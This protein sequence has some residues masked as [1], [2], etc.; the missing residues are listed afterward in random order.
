MVFGAATG[1][2]T[3][4]GGTT[5]LTHSGFESFQVSGSP[6]TDTLAGGDG[7]D[8]LDMG[9]GRGLASGGAGADTLSAD[10]SGEG[11]G[12]VFR[13]A[14]GTALAGGTQVLAHSGFESFHVRG[15]A[16]N[17][18]MAGG[19]GNDWLDLGM[20]SGLASGGA[21]TD[22]LGVDF[23]N[24]DS[25]VVF[26]AT[27]SAVTSRRRQYHHAFWFRGIPYSWLSAWRYPVRRRG[28]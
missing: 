18:T 11:T 26:S 21:G 3:T 2:A 5:V 15:T 23:S 22:M 9:A 20:G 4:S 10:F 16:S 19:S 1:R 6:G 7:N 13:A 28:R 12:V 25:G 24:Q 8:W 27:G 14:T 17:D